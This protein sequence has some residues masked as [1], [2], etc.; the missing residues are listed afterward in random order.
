MNKTQYRIIFNK[1]RGCM[2]V[3]A[4]TAQAQGKSA[5]G[6]TQATRPARQYTTRM[7][8]ATAAPMQL[9]CWLVAG[10][11]GWS[12]PLMHSAQ[13]QTT[14]VSM[15]TRIVADPNAPKTQQPTVLTTSNG[16]VQVNIQTPSAAGVSR[17]TFNQ[18]DVGSQGVILNNSRTNV[19]TQQGGWVQG[20]PSLAAGSARVILNEVNSVNPSYLQGYVEVAGQKAEVI[21][22]KQRNGPTGVVKLAFLNKITKFESLASGASGDF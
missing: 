5:S 11:L 9:A 19:Q 15:V 6:Q 18:F 12:L 4:E 8:L 3:V 21:I 2:M 20:N 1:S 10:I 16:V 7:A 13:A 17:N 14:A 22:A